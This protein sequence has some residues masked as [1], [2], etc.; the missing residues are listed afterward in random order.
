LAGELSAQYERIFT[1]YR[2]ALD[3]L[4]AS[5]ESVPQTREDLVQEIL[6]AIWKALPRFRG[7]CSERTF[8]FRVAHNRCLTHVWRRGKRP[9]T[10]E[11]APE[12]PD[13]RAGPE[14]QAIEN[15]RRQALR[16]A[17]RQ[18]P[19]NYRQVILLALEDLSP[20]EIAGVLGVTE[21]NV[22][23]RLNRARKALR[24][25]LEKHA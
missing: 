8:V 2:P 13:T 22:G 16:D 3:R 14:T 6:L 4:A 21:N 25:I 1:E 15:R 7:D 9:E 19:L 17:I 12:T 23:V 11:E 24:S 10:R 5:Y 18:L 20:P